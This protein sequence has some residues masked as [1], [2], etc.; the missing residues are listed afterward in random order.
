MVKK[1]IIK[2]E[3]NQ[4]HLIILEKNMLDKGRSKK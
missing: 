1:R 4:S 2:L 3:E